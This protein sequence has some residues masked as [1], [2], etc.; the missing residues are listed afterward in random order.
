MKYI[1]FYNTIQEFVDGEGQQPDGDNMVSEFPG[2]AYTLEADIVDY[3]PL[4]SKALV[5]ENMTQT[6][7][8]IWLIATGNAPKIT[9]EWSTDN[10]LYTSVSSNDTPVAGDVI[11]FTLPAGGSLYIKGNNTSMATSTGDFWHFSGSTN[12]QLSGDIMQIVAD[13]EEMT[14]DYEFAG[15]FEWDAQLKKVNNGVLSSP[16]VSNYGYYNMF[17]GAG[18]T[19]M[20]SLTA[21]TVG[22]YGYSYMFRN[23]TFRTVTELPAMNIGQ[24]CYDNMFRYSQV[25]GMTGTLPA[26]ALS[27]YCY[28]A[29]FNNCR[30]LTKAPEIMAKNANAYCF[31]SMFSECRALVIP[32]VMHI[33]RLDG[34]EVTN[35]AIECCEYMFMN[36]TSL[37]G[38]PTFFQNIQTIS[39]W[40]AFQYMFWGCT[41]LTYAAPLPATDAVPYCYTGMFLNCT[42]LATPP[43][44][45]LTGVTQG[46][47]QGGHCYRMFEGCTALTA[48]PQINVTTLAPSCFV[49]MFKGCTSI[50]SISNLPA[51]E[52][53]RD[54]YS[55]MFSGCTNLNSV[56]A[57]F[58]ECPIY[59]QNT[60][61]EI[62]TI[63]GWMDGV[64]ATGTFT[65]NVNA[66]WANSDVVPNGWTVQTANQ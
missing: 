13:E 19:E 44:I 30:S 5:F 17:N 15:L 53:K 55:G 61:D 16:V 54:C 34:Q 24:H 64:S 59:D 32:P 7:G 33:E 36:C 45:G 41:N 49:D 51:L 23:A 57:M 39:S 3:N 48:T 35:K 20:P 21:N 10:S 26:T 9:L 37:T 56:K 31:A 28:V 14:Q 38:T 42:K 60:G 25:T 50:S 18:L 43:T 4:P 47:G 52:L 40:Y 63:T 62:P 29:M 2:V 6:N 8:T 46:H 22:D 58:L 27:W 65:K 66:T 11:T 12:Y 1:L